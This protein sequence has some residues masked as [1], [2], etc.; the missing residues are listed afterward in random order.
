MDAAGYDAVWLAE[1]H[2]TGYSVC[3]SVHMLGVAAANLTERLR[4]GTGVSLAALYHPL[5][6][7]QDAA[8]ASLRSEA[9]LLERVAAL[10]AERERVVSALVAQGWTVATTQANFVWLRLGDRTMDFAAACEAAGVVVR[11]FAGEGAR[12][13]IGETEANDLFLETAELFRKGL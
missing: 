10:V 7:A 11:P 1:H 2:F 9:A 4:I 3:P 13:T 6:L 5:R 8:V 12:I